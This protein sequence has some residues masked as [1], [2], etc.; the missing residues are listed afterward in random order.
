[1]IIIFV[2]SL[3]VL[4]KL[5]RDPIEE[6]LQNVDRQPRFKNYRPVVLVEVLNDDQNGF[7]LINLQLLRIEHTVQKLDS[8]LLLEY[9]VDPDGPNLNR[10]GLVIL[11]SLV[12][13]HHF[14]KVK[15]IDVEG[16][17]PPN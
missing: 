11:I 15:V 5:N 9:P 1:M 2:N 4:V 7:I 10:I 3:Q 13:D 6:K 8:I 12:L 17:R 16:I 14:L